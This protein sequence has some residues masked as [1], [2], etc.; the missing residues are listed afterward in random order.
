[1]TLTELARTVPMEVVRDGEFQSLGLMSHRSP[2]LLA[3]L[4]DPRAVRECRRN[5]DLAG[6]ITMPGLADAVPRHL[7][8]A[9]APAPRVSFSDAQRF[10]VNETDFYGP[11]TASSIAADASVHPSAV[12]AEHNVHIGAGCLIE[13]GAVILERTTL[14]AAVVVRAGAVIGAE[15]FHPNPHDQGIAN[16]THGGG[17]RVGP[18][19]QVLSNAVI[20][21]SVFTSP[22][23]IGARTVI[24]PLAYVAHGVRTGSDCRLAASARVAG[25]A[26]LGNGVYVGPNAVV[27]NDVRVDD[28]ARISIGAI[29]VKDV[30]PGQTVTGYFAVEHNR[31]L[32]AWR[33]LTR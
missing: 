9:V 6:I 25:S 14:D 3:C 15:G 1:M 24:G 7:A 23:E 11:D 17:V 20:C 16:L 21:R 13:P 5:P 22:T 32:S 18:G 4:Y 33:R 28:G 30:P 26:I 19:A 2:A 29:V 8:L 12:V 27:S 10:L 31:F